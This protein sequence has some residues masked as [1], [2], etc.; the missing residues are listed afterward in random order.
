[1]EK[2]S[3]RKIRER[4]LPFTAEMAVLPVTKAEPCFR[5]DPGLDYLPEVPAFN[6]AGNLFVTSPSMGAVFS[7]TPLKKKSAIFFH[8]HVKFLGMEYP[9]FLPITGPP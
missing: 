3:W 6:L 5:I 9:V 8:K 1:M 7:L 4:A 2:R